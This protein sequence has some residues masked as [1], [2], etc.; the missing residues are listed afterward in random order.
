MM[1]ANVAAAIVVL[2]TFSRVTA[3]TPWPNLLEA[4][5]VAFLFAVCTGPL[6][7]ITM[8]R[9]GPH[10]WHRFV[11][12]TNWAVMVVA[13]AALAAVGCLAAIGL[14]GA[15]GYIPWSDFFTW[16]GRSIRIAI[17]ITLT[18]GIFVTAY[19]LL[20]ARLAE[21]T[22]ALRTME[23]DEAEARRL[24]TEAL[25][26]SL[27]SRVQPHFLFNTLNSI[28]SLIPTD[29]AGAERMTG[30]LASLLRSSLDTAA[31]PV[32]T[33]EQELQTVRDYLDIER[34]R[35]GDRL[36]YTIEAVPDLAAARV[37]RLSVQTLVE[38]SVKYAVSPSREG[39][40]IAI[41]AERQGPFLQLEVQ[42]DGPGF[43]PA[44]EPANHGLALL[45]DRL[46]MTFGADAAL[47]I[48]NTGSGT[49]ARMQVPL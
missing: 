12:P 48:R 45:R 34:V 31:T 38:N 24:A 6:L 41:R 17:V 32:V 25:F 21:T 10:V 28:A 44:D 3:N 27:E 46:R 29:P 1:A 5:G 42:D 39:A 11:F 2:L 18:F 4:F 43:Q 19:E 14:L 33:L 37:P 8:P 13:M 47:V 9:L 22:L 30:Q 26:A 40:A 36:R 16:F 23:R 15:I 49:V 20:N 7:A 35:F